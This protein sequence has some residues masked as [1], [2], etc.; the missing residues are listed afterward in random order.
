MN[1]IIGIYKITNPEG[2]VYIGQTKD[3]NNRFK[4]Y[5]RLACKGQKKLYASLNKYGVENHTFEVVKECSIN[6]LNFWERYYQEFYYVLDNDF[7]LNLKY[8]NVGEKKQVVSDC[9]KEKISN[10]LKEKYKSGEI[11]SS[12]KGKKHT[13]DVKTKLSIA[14][15]GKIISD[16]TKEKLRII[17]LGKKASQETKNKMSAKLKGDK[18][19]S[20]K[21]VINVITG[22]IYGCAKYAWQNQNNGKTLGNFRAKLNGGCPNDTNF[23]YL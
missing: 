13:D 5:K 9:S 22:E 21:K 3:I 8:V 2:A 15:T 11:K 23:K 14:H 7:G 4:Y 16:A 12:F 17:N 18:N 19:P 6:E 1:K 10:T 20:A